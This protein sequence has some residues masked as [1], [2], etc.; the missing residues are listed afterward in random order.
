MDFKNRIKTEP[1]PLANGWLE[2]DVHCNMGSLSNCMPLCLR[3][4]TTA[5]P[6][7]IILQT[8]AAS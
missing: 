3:S 5:Y 2:S 1:L 6:G 8:E 4:F 7:R